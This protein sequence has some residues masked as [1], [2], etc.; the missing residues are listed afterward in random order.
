MI[1]LREFQVENGVPARRE[2]QVENG[3]PASTDS[4]SIFPLSTPP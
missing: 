2:F 4:F 1:N 3:V